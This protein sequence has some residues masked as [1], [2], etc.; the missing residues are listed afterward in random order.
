MVINE[1]FYTNFESVSKKRVDEVINKLSVR[2]CETIIRVWNPNKKVHKP[3]FV[4]AKEIINKV[5][6]LLYKKYIFNKFPEYTKLEVIEVIMELKSK[7]R[8]VLFKE[9]SVLT[10]EVSEEVTKEEK[11]KNKYTINKMKDLLSEGKTKLDEFSKTYKGIFN[12]L[13]AD[14]EEVL[15]AIDML[16]SED[17][18]ILQ[19]KFGKNYEE[20]NEVSVEINTI[21]N[22]RIIVYIRRNIKRL[23]EGKHIKITD[24]VED[25]RNME[26]IKERVEAMLPEEKKRLTTLFGEDLTK[27]FI[28]VNPNSPILNKNIINKLNDKKRVVKKKGRPIKELTKSLLKFKREG[29]T[30]EEFTLR[31]KEAI[32]TLTD[33]EKELL[34][35]KYGKDLKNTKSE[36]LSE[37]ES[38]RLVH[39]I[40]YKIRWQLVKQNKVREYKSILDRCDEFEKY[41]FDE[42]FSSLTSEEQNLLKKVYGENLDKPLKKGT[43]SK[44]ELNEINSIVCKFERFAIKKYK[45]IYPSVKLRTLLEMNRVLSRDKYEEIKDVYG[46]ME[47]LAIITYIYKSSYATLEEIE[48]VTNVKKEDILKLAKEYLESEYSFRLKK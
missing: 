18:E 14:R 40:K 43:I 46:K 33:E 8:E 37:E 5:N 21:I 4:E 29:E 35:R 9:Y 1:D 41:Y 19:K 20:L 48:T 15:K 7:Q 16:K 27:E 32:N 39:T 36:I 38:L 26:V 47:A 23:R 31:I 2:D 11:V 12:Q 42:F 30:K 10:N 28:W 17:K 45:C 13:K 25:T 6:K 24:F 3:Y 44:A 22:T 34:I